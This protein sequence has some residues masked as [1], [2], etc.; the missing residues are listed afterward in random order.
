MGWLVEKA[1]IPRLYWSGDALN[2]DLELQ[3]ARSEDAVLGPQES[4]TRSPKTVFAV[5]AGKR[6]PVVCERNHNLSR[7][8][9]S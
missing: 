1:P 7:S 3:G 2:G 8:P 9:Y 6:F 4:P 5:A